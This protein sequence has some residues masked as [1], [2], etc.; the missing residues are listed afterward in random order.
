[1]L[2]YGGHTNLPLSQFFDV[3]KFW[4]PRAEVCGNKLDCLQTD[5]GGE[6]I[7]ATLQSFC[8]ERGIKI[9]YAAPYIHEENKIAEQC[10]KILVQMKDSLLIDSKLLNQF[11]AKAMDI[12]NYL[13]NRF[14]IRRIADKIIIIPEEA[15]TEVRQN[16]EHIQIF[17]SRV[18]THILSEKRFKSDVYKT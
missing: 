11:W 14:L 15:W 1:M 9:G 3:F 2:T 18:S 4:I 17:G 8:K 16:L 12:A 6:F 7:S 5:G 10:W 13:W